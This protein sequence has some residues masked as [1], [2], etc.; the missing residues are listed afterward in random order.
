MQAHYCE[1][2][3]LPRRPPIS[4]YRL[5]FIGEFVVNFD[6]SRA[7]PDARELLKLLAHPIGFERVA[8]VFG[9]RRSIPLSYG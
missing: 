4:R 3:S 2:E 8:F 1:G 6:L 5:I 7:L 9:G